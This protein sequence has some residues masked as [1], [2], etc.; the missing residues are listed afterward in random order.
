MKPSDIP[1]RVASDLRRYERSL[2]DDISDE[3]EANAVAE[4]LDTLERGKPV[5]G[6]LAGDYIIDEMTPS[7]LANAV[8]RLL[9]GREIEQMEA[10]HEL[11]K[12]VTEGA[13]EWLKTVRPM[14][15]ENKV[16]EMLSED[17]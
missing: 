8:T 11:Q 5:A 1:C 14:A 15:V 10:R 17:E 16:Q 13:G 12:F 3:D 9:Y 6:V 2:R 7:V 4:L